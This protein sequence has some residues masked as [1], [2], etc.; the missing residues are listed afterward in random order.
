[1]DVIDNDGAVPE[2]RSGQMILSVAEDLEETV[3]SVAREYSH[4]PDRI[5]FAIHIVQQ[6]TYRAS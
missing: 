6:R 4:T 1:M 2:R 3:E 5:A